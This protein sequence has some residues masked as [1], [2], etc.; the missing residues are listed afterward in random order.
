MT[1]SLLVFLRILSST[2][3]LSLGTHLFFYL[4]TDNSRV[5]HLCLW[6]GLSGSWVSCCLGD[7]SSWLPQCSSWTSCPLLWSSLWFGP[8]SSEGWGWSSTFPPS[9]PFFPSPHMLPRPVHSASVILFKSVFFSFRGL[10]LCLL[11]IAGFPDHR[12]TV[13]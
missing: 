5:A 4:G 13:G 1:G 2:F 3:F 9:L 8:P 12:V 11:Y 6:S 7:M 10:C